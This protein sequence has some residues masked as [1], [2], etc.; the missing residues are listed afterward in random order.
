M[1][2]GGYFLT[3]R[4]N[5]VPSKLGAELKAMFDCTDRCSVILC[6]LS[7]LLVQISGIWEYLG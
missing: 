2:S 1:L 4:T 3:H 7:S 6:I 5:M